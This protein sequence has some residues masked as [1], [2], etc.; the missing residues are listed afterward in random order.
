MQKRRNDELRTGTVG[1][2]KF[3]RAPSNAAKGADG[4]QGTG[5][6]LAIARGIMEA[7]GG[8]VSAESPVAG[9][10]GTRVTMTFPR[11]ETT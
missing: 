8:T 2:E 3:F 10:H 11:E 6:G 5:L 1:F 7:H 9:G 4:G